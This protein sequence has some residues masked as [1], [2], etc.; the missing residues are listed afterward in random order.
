MK[1]VQSGFTIVELLIVIVVIAILATITIVAYNGIQDRAKASAASQAL[2]NAV[3]KIKYWQAEQDSTLSPADLATAGVTNTASV[4]YQ[5]NPGTTGNYCITAT[6]GGKSYYI[7]TTTTTSTSG[8][9]PGHGQGGV[10]AI[11]NLSTNP[12]VETTTAGW[13]Q[14]WGT[15]GSGTATRMTDGGWSGNAYFRMTWNAAPT[16]T[17]GG[18]NFGSIAVSEG[19]PLTASIWIR[20]LTTQSV[21]F[22]LRP[23]T[24]PTGTD[25][26]GTLASLSPNTWTRLSVTVSATPAGITS[27]SPFTSRSGSGSWQI[28]D[29]L[30]SDALMITQDTTAHNYADGNSTDWTWNTN[31]TSTGPPL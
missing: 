11:T 10:A 25:V 15:S 9:C 16:V 17:W 29:R 27:Y 5:Y 1:R 6:V 21:R 3:K 24:Y 12:S 23:N 2:A 26:P 31:S 13:S 28:N 22:Y 8:G 18:V 14:N 20:S 7:S 4:N 30:D 19:Q